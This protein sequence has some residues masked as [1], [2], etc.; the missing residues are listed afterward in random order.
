MTRD[1]IEREYELLEALLAA[2]F[3]GVAELRAQAASV[4][5]GREGLIVDL[6]VDPLAPAA[7]VVARV[8]VQ[9][10]VD[11]EGYDGGLLL[12]VDDGRLSAIEYWWVTEDPPLSMPPLA[13]VGR[14]IPTA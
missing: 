2:E 4:R 7:P 11:G 6:M 8:P 9:A 3:P 12:V 13:V 5:A 14:A 1:L 10:V